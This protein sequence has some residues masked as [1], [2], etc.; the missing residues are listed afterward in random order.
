MSSIAPTLEAFFTDRLASQRKASEHTVAAYRDTFRLLLAYVHEISGKAPS[1]LDFTDVDATVVAGFLEHL[2]RS[3]ANT[4]RSRNARLAAIHSFFRWAAFR[5]PEHAALIQRVLAIPHKRFTSSLLAFLTREEVDAILTMPDRSTWIGRRDH[6]ILL[7]A[8][9][10]GL[11][12]AE[13]TGLTCEDVHLGVGAHIRC[14]GKGRKERCTP[15]TRQTVAVLRV[16]LQERAGRPGELL[17]PSRLGG[18]LSGDALQSLVANYV[19]TAG[20][21]VPS[22]QS[23]NVTPMRFVTPAPCDFSTLASTRP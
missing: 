2:E 7:L 8:L 6:A 19:E 5:H 3:R 11:R 9:Q 13:L 4:V 15:L 23:K 17:F 14:R 21:Q 16:W 10:A 20:R 1:T 22:L 12:A 18:R